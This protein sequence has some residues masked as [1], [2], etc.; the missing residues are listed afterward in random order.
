MLKISELCSDIING[1]T[2][3]KSVDE[4]WNSN[5]IFWFTTPDFDDLSI[6]INSAKQYV[7]K[8]A[9]EDNKVKIV[10]INSVLLSCTATLGKTGV[11]QTELCTNQQI[12]ALVCNEKIKPFF[13]AYYFRYSDFTLE[14]L[15]TNPG[16]QHINIPTLKQIKI[17]VPPLSEQQRIVEEV[18]SYEAAI[19]QA[20]AVMEGCAERK[21]VI[22]EKWLG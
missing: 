19:A 1:G 13:M 2:P 12:N 15:T 11:V 8:K 5:D 4:Y 20:K 16:V 10:P 22:L 14:G 3:L 17:P 18:E 9:F 21:K 6:R 7:S